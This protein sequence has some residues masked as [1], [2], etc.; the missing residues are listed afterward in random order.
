MTDSLGSTVLLSQDFVHH[1]YSTAII[2]ITIIFLE[3]AGGFLLFFCAFW[4][5]T[6]PSAIMS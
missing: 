5:F 6:F 1:K 4:E 3:R 2:I